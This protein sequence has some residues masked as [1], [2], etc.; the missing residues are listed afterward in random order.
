MN[1]KVTFLLLATCLLSAGAFASTPP[2]SPLRID[3]IVAQQTQIRDEALAGTGRY[4]DMPKATKDE[5][6]AKQA[7][8]L[9]MLD[10]KHDTGELSAAQRVEA[11]NTLEWIEAAINKDPDERMVC[12]RER[13]TGSLHVSTVCKT[14]RQ[15]KDANERARRQ[16]EGS[17]PIDI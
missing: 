3:D 9:K 1:R 11:F 5:L 16:M 10:G 7:A 6:L 13:R 8:L 15:I 12:R 17:S 14:Q 2:A 4:K